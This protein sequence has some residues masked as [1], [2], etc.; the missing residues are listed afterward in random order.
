MDLQREIKRPPLMDADDRAAIDAAV[1]EALGK[2]YHFRVIGD[3]RNWASV[4]CV[5][6]PSDP[7]EQAFPPNT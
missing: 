7:Q 3:G 5:T 4:E 1:A 2:L 6:A